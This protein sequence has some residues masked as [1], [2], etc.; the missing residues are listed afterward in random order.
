MSRLVHYR[1]QVF[2]HT[3]YTESLCGHVLR[4]CDTTKNERDVE[5]QNCLRKLHANTLKMDDTD[6]ADYKYKPKEDF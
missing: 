1:K 4:E 3:G 2:E 5:C 6:E